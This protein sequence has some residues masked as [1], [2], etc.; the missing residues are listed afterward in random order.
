ML[1]A[2]PVTRA[3]MCFPGT[4]TLNGPLPSAA[5]TAGAASTGTG[6]DEPGTAAPSAVNAVGTGGNGVPATNRAYCAGSTAPASSCEPLVTLTVAMPT[7][8]RRW[9]PGTA[10]TARCSAVLSGPVAVITA[11]APACCHDVA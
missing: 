2:W 1:A 11:S 4:S 9:T 7:A 10:A 6:P 3:W 8:A 5:A